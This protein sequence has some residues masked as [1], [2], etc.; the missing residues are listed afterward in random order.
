VLD[1]A[2]V[3]A[4]DETVLTLQAQLARRA[5]PI[6]GL[7]RWMTSQRAVPLERLV[8]ERSVSQNTTA[9]GGNVALMRLDSSTLA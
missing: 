8:A 7:W 1:F 6:I 4:D 5:G 3:C 9:S 2:L